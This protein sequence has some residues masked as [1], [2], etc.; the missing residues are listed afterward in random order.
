M[1]CLISPLFD[2]GDLVWGDRNNI[3][4]MNGLQI[5]HNKAAKCILDIPSYASSTEALDMLNWCP[6][7]S[8][9]RFHRC[10]F[11]F[12]ALNSEVD[13]LFSEVRAA[14]DIHQYDTRRK[15][16]MRLP[17]CKTKWGQQR[18]QYVMIKDWNALPPAITESSGLLNFK[19]QYFKYI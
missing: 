10:S 19:K 6:L 4:L 3:T 1:N 7:S 5:L 11:V 9:R 17:F 16:M 18:S 15:S 2:Y 14:Q 12:K 13:F 8:R